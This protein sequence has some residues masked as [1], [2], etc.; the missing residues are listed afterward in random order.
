MPAAL[1]P[2][3]EEEKNER[4]KCYF[5]L[6]SEEGKDFWV[7]SSGLSMLPLFYRG[8]RVHINTKFTEPQ[9][10]QIVVFH[11]SDK[12]IAHRLINFNHETGH[13]TTK[14]DTLFFFDGPSNKGDFLGVVD[15]VERHGKI[16]PVRND[17]ELA[18]LSGKLGLIL[19][20]K[21]HRLPNWIKFLF[22]FVMF[23]PGCGV[24]RCKRWLAPKKGW[25]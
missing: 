21:L 8:V 18:H 3:S 12:F 14:G 13:Y 2:E 16:L 22:Y 4:L 23:L 1:N 9:P 5:S 7:E 11:R 17:P 19:A 24:I 20:T 25:N 6:L 15:L 10:G